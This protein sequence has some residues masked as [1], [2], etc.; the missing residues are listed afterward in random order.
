[1]S[2]DTAAALHAEASGY[3]QALA[4]GQDPDPAALLLAA[5]AHLAVSRPLEEIL[6]EY[7][8][9]LDAHSAGEAVDLA[10]LHELMAEL[11]PV[12]KAAAILAG[13]LPASGTPAAGAGAAVPAPAVT[14]GEAT[15]H[16]LV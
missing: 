8:P 7:S 14:A 6:A 2:G 10:R 15:R 16:G 4:A 1:M 5:R 11:G 13:A 12:R 9:L 3:G